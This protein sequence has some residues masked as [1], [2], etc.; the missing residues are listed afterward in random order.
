MKKTFI[1]L[2]LLL[3][4]TTFAQQTTVA[5]LPSEGTSLGNEELEMLTD[6]MRKAALKVL[7]TSSFVLLKQDVVVKRLGCSLHYG[8]KKICPAV[9]QTLPS[10]V[11]P[12]VWN[13]S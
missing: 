13:N 1:T 12:R 6:K 7:P 10:L 8:L 5:V 2:L 3:S 4:L 9:A 11:S